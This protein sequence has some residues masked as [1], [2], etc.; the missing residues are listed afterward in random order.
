MKTWM[1]K[2]LSGNKRFQKQKGAAVMFD[3]MTLCVHALSLCPVSGVS[4][5]SNDANKHRS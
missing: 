4:D 2:N 3:Y 1:A 5:D